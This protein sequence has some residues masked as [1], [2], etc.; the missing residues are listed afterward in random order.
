MEMKST[1]WL[2][3]PPQVKILRKESYWFKGFGSVVAVDQVPSPSLLFLCVR[4]WYSIFLYLSLCV[5]ALRWFLRK[6]L[7][8]CRTRTLD[9]RSWFGSTKWIMLM[10][11]RTTTHWMRFKKFNWNEFAFIICVCNPIVSMSMPPCCKLVHECVS[12]SSSFI[13]C[14]VLFDQ[15]CKS[16]LQMSQKKKKK[17]I[18]GCP[19]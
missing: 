13:F 8:M 15:Y 11:P 2:L 9:T 4:I 1:C 3:A 10:Y 18:I 19:R 12:Y 5:I 17:F 6:N 7:T 16:V 14:S